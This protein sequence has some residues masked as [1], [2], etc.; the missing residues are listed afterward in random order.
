MSDERRIPDG[1]AAT[2][3]TFAPLRLRALRRAYLPLTPDVRAASQTARIHPTGLLYAPLNGPSLLRS[4]IHHSV[5]PNIRRPAR[6][7]ASA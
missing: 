1:V 6:L 5:S 2:Y 7:W 3:V 4:K